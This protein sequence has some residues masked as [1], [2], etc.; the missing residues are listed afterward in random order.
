MNL[1]NTVFPEVSAIVP[2][3]QQVLPAAKNLYRGDHV[4]PAEL[5][6]FAKRTQPIHLA[7]LDDP[8]KPLIKA[9]PDGKKTLFL[10]WGHPKNYLDTNF[11]VSMVC[12]EQKDTQGKTVF[13]PNVMLRGPL[14]NVMVIGGMSCCGSALQ[15]HWS[16][17]FEGNISPIDDAR[18]PLA[19][20]PDSAHANWLKGKVHL[21]NSQ[22][23][24]SALNHM[25]IDMFAHRLPNDSR[26]QHNCSTQKDYAVY[27]NDARKL[28][29]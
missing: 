24:L 22:A 11:L 13:K 21:A 3:I 1:N 20:L 7:R 4:D 8:Q 15:T 27:A 16:Q 10:L 29:L 12:P 26:F 17:V 18:I 25:A 9:A 23:G 14:A 2:L 28:T 5:L 19:G 6:D